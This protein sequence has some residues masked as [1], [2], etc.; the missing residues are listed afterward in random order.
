MNQS[1]PERIEA[2]YEEID[3]AVRFLEAKHGNRLRCGPGCTSC[4]VD[5]ITV[6]SIEAENIRSRYAGTLG[7]MKPH[8]I[9]AC[10]F[11]D[12]DGTCRIY[13]WRP[14]VCRT[15]GLPLHWTEE[16]EDGTV[17]AFRDICP[18][19]EPGIPVESLDEDSCWTIGPVEE[20]LARL[21]HRYRNGEM[22]R[23]ALRELFFCEKF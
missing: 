7:K 12:G 17:V 4:C 6:W 21:Q 9:G 22:T 19:N 23:V 10:A 5:E 20:T 15:Q 18:E 3:A 2:L 1:L 16:Q 11:L 13:R 8:L 14:Y